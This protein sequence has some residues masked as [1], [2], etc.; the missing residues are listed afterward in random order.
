MWFISHATETEIRT[1]V[2]SRTKTVPTLDKRAFGFLEGFVDWIFYAEPIHSTEDGE[3]RVLR[4][5]AAEEYIA[6]GRIALPDPLPLDA[7]QVRKAIE[8][9]AKG[10]SK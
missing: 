9:V 8:A 5:A 2:G 4:T 6:G 1:R 3:Q 7:P 10:G